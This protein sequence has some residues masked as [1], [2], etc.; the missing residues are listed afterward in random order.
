MEESGAFVAGIAQAIL[1]G[2]PHEDRERSPRRQCQQARGPPSGAPTAIPTEA[3]PEGARRRAA[4]GSPK[5][6][7]A[8]EKPEAPPLKSTR[9]A[10]P[11]PWA[12]APSL[13]EEVTVPTD[14]ELVI[15]DV[16]VVTNGGEAL[17]EGWRV[18]NG[19]F[20]LD[21][22]FIQQNL[23]RGEVRGP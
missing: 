13:P 22:V 4:E 7:H 9:A 1:P 21:E 16:F 5:R 2:A 8:E 11:I 17:P 10:P 18:V 19:E 6:K 3:E 14:D 23:R 12:P 15:D 20:E